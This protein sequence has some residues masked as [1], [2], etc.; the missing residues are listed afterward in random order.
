MKALRE[1]LALEG[2][3]ILLAEHDL[4]VEIETFPEGL[5]DLGFMIDDFLICRWVHM[6]STSLIILSEI[7]GIS[8]FLNFGFFERRRD[9]FGV[10]SSRYLSSA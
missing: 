2:V 7:A 10:P 8:S 9:S 3:E 6:S 5:L 4:V 1:E